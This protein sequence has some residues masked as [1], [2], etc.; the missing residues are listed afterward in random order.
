[1]KTK[2]KFA[3]GTY[4]IKPTSGHRK[5]TRKAQHVTAAKE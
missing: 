1:M 2:L 5:I 4:E 3:P